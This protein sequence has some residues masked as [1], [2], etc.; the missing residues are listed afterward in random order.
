MLYPTL[1]HL[2]PLFY[3]PA[4]LSVL[5]TQLLF[6]WFLTECFWSVVD[7]LSFISYRSL[8]N[9][10]FH[11]LTTCL[12]CVYLYLVIFVVVVVV[13]FFFQDFGWSSLPLFWIQGNSVSHSEFWSVYRFDMILVNLFAKMHGCV[14]VLLEDMYGVYCTWACWL[15]GGA[16]S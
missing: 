11:L 1:L 10:F 2:F 13:F 12:Q 4:H 5:L 6:C 9:I 3:L 16:W 8:L 14:P 7:W 15:L